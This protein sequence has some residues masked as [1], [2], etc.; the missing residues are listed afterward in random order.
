METRDNDDL[1]LDQTV[2]EAV[3]KTPEQDPALVTMHE[4]V[5]L[6]P[7]H[8]ILES[9]LYGREELL[10]Q[11]CALTLV[12]AIAR[13][14]V[15]RGE[16]AENRRLQPRDRISLSTCSHGMPNGR[17]MRMSSSSSA[18]RRSNSAL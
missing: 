10:A 2:D 9:S 1:V 15:R 16:R 7:R 5:T 8:R 6:R 3:G 12:P 17:P 14:H 18:S 11:A 4:W 13:L